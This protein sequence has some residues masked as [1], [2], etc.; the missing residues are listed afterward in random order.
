VRSR[1]TT[2]GKTIGAGAVQQRDER[3]DDAPASA[4]PSP[5]Q[6][7][8]PRG[9]E[10]AVTRQRRAGRSAGRRPHPGAVPRPPRS[11]RGGIAR[12]GDADRLGQ[13]H[14]ALFDL[15][16]AQHVLGKAGTFDEIRVAA[17]A[18][19]PDDELRDRIADALPAGVEAT[20]GK[21]VADERAAALEDDL[22]FISTFLLVFAGI[23]VFVG[24]FIIWN[25]F[26]ILVAQRL[27]S[28]RCCVPSGR[29]VGRCAARCSS[30][31]RQSGWS[32]RSQA[33]RSAW[34]WLACSCCCSGRPAWR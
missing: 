27:V 4:A 31:L 14:H 25:T 3:T 15:A 32:A 10:V 23:A 2:A 21:A 24:S 20:T 1:S 12:F 19:V 18:G 8:A 22:G 9:R 34:D 6:G 5:T 11:S 26:S 7:R 29:R 33:S 30:R 28:S 16:T 13:H 17:A